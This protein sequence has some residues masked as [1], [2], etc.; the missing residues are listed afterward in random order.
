[1]AYNQAYVDTWRM[2]LAEK[3]VDDARIEEKKMF[4]GVCLMLNGNMLGG[5]GGTGKDQLMF[6]VGKELEAEALALVG[7]QPVEMGGKKMGGLI[8]VKSE[9]ALENMSQLVDYC[10]TFV[11]GLPPK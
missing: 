3:N 6:R 10:L 1:M 11:G 7:G 9:I 8:F 5:V 2:T 4:G